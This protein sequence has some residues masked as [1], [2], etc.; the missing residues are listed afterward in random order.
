MCICSLLVTVFGGDFQGIVV[1]LLLSRCV[2]WFAKMVV[3][4]C[5]K[6]TLVG[7]LIGRNIF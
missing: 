3:V 5:T 6:F 1:Y 2:M 7:I 4:V